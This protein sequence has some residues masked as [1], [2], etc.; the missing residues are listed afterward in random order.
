A[1]S[2]GLPPPSRRRVDGRV[3]TG[4]YRGFRHREGAQGGVRLDG[5][6]RAGTVEGAYLPDR[7]PRLLRRHR[8]LRSDRHAGD[9]PVEARPCDRSGPGNRRRRTRI[10]PSASGDTGSERSDV[11]SYRIL[12]LEGIT[13]RGMQLLRSEGW[14]VDVQKALPPGELASL[15]GP[16]HAL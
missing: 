15:I 16:Y 11:L 4:G 1:A 2:P 8:H 12:V 13:D 3:P 6:G 9:R 14:Q 7:P 5:R 10:P